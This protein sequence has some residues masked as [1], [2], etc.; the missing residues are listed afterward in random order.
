MKTHLD[1][2]DFTAK[3]VEIINGTMLGD[4]SLH[5][6]PKQQEWNWK[7]TTR[8]SKVDN[9]GINK[10]SYVAWI[11]NQLMPYSSKMAERYNRNQLIIINGKLVNE[12]N[13]DKTYNSYS[14]WT[15]AHPNI[16]QLGKKWYKWKDD[17]LVLNSIGRKIKV[18]PPDITITP[19]TLCVWYMD[20]GSNSPKDAN[21]ALCTHGFTFEEVI[22]LIECLK[23]D[24]NL[25]AT[26]RIEKRRNQPFIFIPRESYFDF[27]DIIRPHVAWD[28]F[29]YKTDT[30]AYNKKTQIG[31]HH[32]QAVLTEE[33][34]RKVFALN[35]QGMPQKDIAKAIGTCKTNI[36]LILSGQRWSHLGL[37][38]ET[39][40]KKTPH[41]KDGQI[42]DVIRLHKEGKSQKA[43]AEYFGINQSTVSRIVRK[44]A[45]N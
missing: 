16:T 39:K 32:S 7:F 3:Q 17:Q 6:Y 4:A 11:F 36:T 25:V 40:R 22:F 13:I 20:D 2:P 33:Q 9:N 26:L 34:V 31:E 15:H 37:K 42:H 28:C 14:Y 38:V 12:K 5:H 24:L 10:A 18:I 23:R 21:A 43:I 41:L 27:M 45:T 30:S 29:H 8:Q 35:K 1:L 44:Y 19:L